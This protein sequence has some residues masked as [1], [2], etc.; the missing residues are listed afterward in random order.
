MSSITDALK[1]LQL[2][3]KEREA[4]LSREY[5]ATQKS[6]QHAETLA[7]KRDELSRKE[8]ESRHKQSTLEYTTYAT[9]TS[10][11]MKS[12]DIFSSPEEIQA[13]KESFEAMYE[14][15][16]SEDGKSKNVNIDTYT[17]AS[18]NRLDKLHK[19]SLVREDVLSS[20]ID[21]VN[22]YDKLIQNAGSAEYVTGS[23]SKLVS[24]LENNYKENQKYLD[25]SEKQEF[26]K[27][28]KEAEQASF[29]LSQM[30]SYDTDKEKEGFQFDEGS[31]EYRASLDQALK[32]LSQG[33]LGGASHVMGQ[34]TSMNIKETGAATDRR[35]SLEATRGVDYG[36]VELVTSGM[37]SG[38]NTQMD[39][40]AMKELYGEDALLLTKI[41]TPKK[42]T[43]SPKT[44]P[45]QITA[46]ANNLSTMLDHSSLPDELSDK[47]EAYQKTGK[48]T[49]LDAIVSLMTEGA[50]D[51]AEGY[52]TF[53]DN[54]QKRA[55][56]Q[57]TAALYKEY[58]RAQNPVV[59]DPD[60]KDPDAKIPEAEVPEEKK[61]DG[62][63]EVVS[64]F[65][66][67]SVF[68]DKEKQDAL[69]AIVSL[70]QELV[71]VDQEASDIMSRNK[72]ASIALTQAQ[73]MW[74]AHEAQ[75]PFWSRRKF[76]GDLF[77]G[78]NP[79]AYD[80]Y[81]DP[82]SRSL[83]LIGDEIK[84]NRNI[85]HETSA[86]QQLSLQKKRAKILESID[87]LSTPL[88]APTRKEIMDALERVRQSK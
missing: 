2:G 41:A 6:I 29:I 35:E 31:G 38:I 44:I 22:D 25:R 43:L 5:A 53:E 51:G 14:P 71:K 70:E 21:F 86:G 66:G 64:S 80:D 73:E 48:L 39:E 26:Q 1:I 42:G 8:R 24:D 63:D 72:Q 59:I 11:L 20:H 28:I 7:L 67:K 65:K 50:E 69:N 19:E 33:N 15:Y 37:V 61:Q 54:S 47:F 3:A 52:F 56:L 36:A 10:D 84:K 18:L 32:L 34:A 40:S 58:R 85:L 83:S 57:D 16:K 27:S 87:L 82:L 78:G 12:L 62:L 17:V 23:M 9:Q 49:D 60:A 13:A 88:G 68:T 45:T 74:N 77:S 81:D 79:D 30:E 75:I 55:L 4:Q 76:A 46:V